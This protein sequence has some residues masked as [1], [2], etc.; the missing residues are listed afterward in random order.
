MPACRYRIDLKFSRAR[1]KKEVWC[2]AVLLSEAHVHHRR[3]V[4]ARMCFC[5]AFVFVLLAENRRF[6]TV[7]SGGHVCIQI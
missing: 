7:W 1:E 2:L 5:H 6:E 4:H 3:D